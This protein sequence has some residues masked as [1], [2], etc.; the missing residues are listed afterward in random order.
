MVQWSEEKD[1]HSDV[2]ADMLLV[3]GVV[4]VVV[5]E[6]SQRVS[7]VYHDDALQA[8]VASAQRRSLI[9]IDGMNALLN[10]IQR[11]KLVKGCRCP[12]LYPLE[13]RSHGFLDVRGPRTRA[14]YKF[15]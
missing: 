6:Q 3:V 5:V 2:V 7:V 12:R 9:A 4:V 10:H 14:E 11:C 13:L 15:K 1:R 8:D